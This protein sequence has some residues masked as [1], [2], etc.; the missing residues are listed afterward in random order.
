MT[1]TPTPQYLQTQ[2]YE[3]LSREVDQGLHNFD[4]V[5]ELDRFRHRG[6]GAFLKERALLNLYGQ[7]IPKR[8]PREQALYSTTFGVHQYASLTFIPGAPKSVLV[9]GQLCLNTWQAAEI[10]PITGDPQL[11]LDLVSL[12]FDDDPV[13]IK[14]FLDAIASLIQRPTQ[15]W[16]FMIL[17]I[18]FQGSGKSFLCEMVAE[19][20]G[21]R[22]T[23]FP[24]VEAIKGNFTGW[25]LNAHL[26]VI[27]ELDRM[28]REVATR[29]KHWI[30]GQKLLINAKNVPEFY[31]RNYAN[32][33]ACSNHDDC[34]HIDEDDRRM[35]TWISRAV[36][37]TAEFYATRWQWFFEGDGLGIVLN[38]LSNRDISLFDPNAAPPKTQ[39]RDRMITN[40]RTEADNFLRDALD[41]I[42][43]PFAHDL[44]TA[45]EVLQYLRVHQIRCTDAEVRR[46]LRECG[47]VSLGQCRVRGSRPNLWAV[48]HTERWANAPHD[49][50]ASAYVSVFDQSILV[51]EAATA[52][53]ASATMPVRRK[54]DSSI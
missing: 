7:D 20:V 36:K 2:A 32:V 30:T 45:S 22:N 4:Y 51:A 50:I 40:S 35:F 8:M 34:L 19:L 26:V 31:V 28:S 1:S 17:I 29:L 6:S 14:F 9:D 52:G 49:E 53:A 38:F 33:I 27:H 37:K 16:A 44:C 24:T 12:I 46:F 47:A 3:L 23:A 18:G 43:P 13:A 10:V 48:R 39:A 54:R 11:F 5:A 41:S 15:K 42:L 21:R 25:L